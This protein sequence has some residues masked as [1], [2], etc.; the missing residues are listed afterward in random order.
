MKTS[1]TLGA[2]PE[3]FVADASGAIS[4]IPLLGD[5]TKEKPVQI[6]NGV[7]GAMYQHDNVMGEVNF[8]VCHDPGMFCE[9]TTAIRKDMTRLLR[10]RADNADVRILKD[11]EVI[12]TGNQL[13]DSLAQVFGCDPDF[14]AYSYVDSPAQ[15]PDISPEAFVIPDRMDG[16]AWRLAG[17]HIHIG[18]NFFCPKHVVVLLCD[19]MITLPY[20]G[21][22]GANVRRNYY[23]QAGRYREK[24]YG[25]E[26]RT[27]NNFWFHN[28]DIA[29]D[30]ASAAARVGRITTSD[31]STARALFSAIP[32]K[33]VKLA[34][35]N[36]DR[37]LAQRIT[38]HVTSK[39]RY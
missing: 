17:G 38:R 39:V 22:D 33:D 36:G 13:D 19:Y 9:F 15:T 2:D 7:A 35:N 20:V 18:G 26:Y 1:Y 29:F 12:F 31:V 8:P 28:A 3:F 11:S 5:G 10:K 23:G 21:I 27:P 37:A 32:W 25:I 30:V 6:D 14:D 34:I 4:A 24:E 16:S